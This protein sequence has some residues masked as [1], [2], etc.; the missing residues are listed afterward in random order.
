MRPQHWPSLAD[1]KPSSVETVLTYSTAACRVS[2]I[3]STAAVR[4]GDDF[5]Q[6]SIRVFEIDTASAVV[7]IDLTQLPSPGIGPVGKLSIPN[8]AENLVEFGFANQERV[9]LRRD[10]AVGV[11]V[12]EIGP[13]FGDDHLKWSP[14]P[15]GW[16]I[17]HLG[18]EYRRGLAVVSRQ[19]RVIEM[20]GHVPSPENCCQS[21][22]A[23]KIASGWMGLQEPHIRIS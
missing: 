8:P 22:A 6:V 13:V 10:F 4:A 7:V 23:V 12:I 1:C 16:K 11:H 17:Q 14:A 20:D 5:K 18:Q 21:L 15:R 2:R 3:P 19:D 9:M